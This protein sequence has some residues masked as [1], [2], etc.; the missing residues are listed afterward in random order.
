M[1]LAMESRTD[2]TAKLGEK[3]DFIVQLSTGCQSQVFKSSHGDD[4]SRDCVL[5]FSFFSNWLTCTAETDRRAG[6]QTDRISLA[7]PPLLSPAV[8]GLSSGWRN[9]GEHAR[10]NR[11]PILCAG[12]GFR[13][14]VHPLM[15]PDPGRL[16]E[17]GLS[18]ASQKAPLSSLS[19][20]AHIWCLCRERC[21][22]RPLRTG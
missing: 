4:K 11:N 7:E 16:W 19:I 12:F 10:V 13:P 17:Q 21:P 6:R 1:H 8:L 15:T 9:P 3:K 5:L 20:T 22:S 18:D 14:L 2:A